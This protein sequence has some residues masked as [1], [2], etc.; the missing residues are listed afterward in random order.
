MEYR[1]RKQATQYLR[2]K[3]VII[4]DNG[5]A[6]LA[7]IGRGPEFQYSGRF[8]LYAEPKL[9]EWAQS[10]LLVQ[11]IRSGNAPRRIDPGTLSAPTTK[12]RSRSP[13]ADRVEA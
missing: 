8:P 7:L 11:G 1:T 10:Q 13:S 5:L 6:R 9:D 2:K 4:S 3:G 12:A